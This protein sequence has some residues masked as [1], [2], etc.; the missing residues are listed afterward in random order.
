MKQADTSK[1]VPL[2]GARKTA[3]TMGPTARLPNSGAP[4]QR[5]GASRRTRCSAPG[6]SPGIPA[7]PGVS[8]SVQR[9]V[10]LRST[11]LPE[12]L[13]SIPANGARW[14]EVGRKG[15]RRTKGGGHRNESD[16][17]RFPPSYRKAPSLTVLQ[18][19]IRSAEWH[20]VTGSR[21]APAC[22]ISMSAYA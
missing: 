20:A 21:E 8:R 4:P 11:E 15:T 1:Q 22:F 18:H 17:V 2:F 10:F 12:R 5:H 7:G 13:P 9:R 6:K 19:S 14:G 16:F 3:K